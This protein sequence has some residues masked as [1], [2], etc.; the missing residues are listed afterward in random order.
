MGYKIVGG[1]SEMNVA[2]WTERPWF[3]SRGKQVLRCRNGDE[4]ASF[5]IGWELFLGWKGGNREYLQPGTS[6][7][8]CELSWVR[9][10]FHGLVRYPVFSAI[11]VMPMGTKDRMEHDCEGS[12][13]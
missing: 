2:W 10:I 9:H 6:D 12:P 8:S 5:L 7:E 1:T 13:P 3:Q 4:C 11:Q